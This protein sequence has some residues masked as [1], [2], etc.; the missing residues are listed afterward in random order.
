MALQR[1]VH[2]ASPIVIVNRNSQAYTRFRQEQTT[3]YIVQ[4]YEP[5]RPAAGRLAARTRRKCMVLRG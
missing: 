5:E 2:N 4:V 1:R 3:S